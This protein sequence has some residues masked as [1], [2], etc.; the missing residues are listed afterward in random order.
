VN[1][2]FKVVIIPASE[3]N[4]SP[5]LP[6]RVVHDI[7]GVYLTLLYHLLHVTKYISPYYALY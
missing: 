1:N 3:W 5:F 7:I 2:L 4:C 6:I